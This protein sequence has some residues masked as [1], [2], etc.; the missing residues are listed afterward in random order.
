MKPSGSVMGPTHDLPRM[1]RDGVLE[2]LTSLL[3]AF[4]WFV[5]GASALWHMACSFGTPRGV[6]ARGPLRGAPEVFR[7]I[8]TLP[9]H[10]TR[11]ESDE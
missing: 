1:G 4:R 2:S 9:C 11:G 5:V 8:S 7:G 3:F 6:E 10:S